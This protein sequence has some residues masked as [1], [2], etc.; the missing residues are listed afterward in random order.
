MKRIFAGRPL[1]GKLFP[2]LLGAGAL[3]GLYAGARGARPPEL[4]GALAALV[5]FL[6]AWNARRRAS[7]G[8]GVFF[9]LAGAALAFLAAELCFTR[10]AGAC[11]GAAG[12]G[13]LLQL[14]ATLLL[15]R[16]LALTGAAGPSR[17]PSGGGAPDSGSPLKTREEREAPARGGTADLERSKRLSDIGTLASTVAHELRNPLTAIRVAARNIKKKAPDPGLA[18]HLAS[19]DRKI[20]E[21]SQIIDNLLFYSRLRPPQHESVD[22]F[23]E[24][25]DCVEDLRESCGWGIAVT[26]DF[27]ALKGARLEADPVQLREV[28]N[29][30]L[31]N[32]RD[33]APPAGGKVL[34]EGLRRGGRVVV[35]VRDNGPGLDGE[36][37][38]K[39]FDP[40][41]TTKAKGTGL[42]LTVCREIAAFHG[43]SI[44]MRSAPGAGT[45]VVVSLPE[46]RTGP[47]AAPP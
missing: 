16:A 37:L 40:F 15:C 6:L 1:P 22:I 33:A 28:L 25:S 4:L 24:L 21:S 31:N 11:G 29:N 39:A 36:T 7:S 43:G 38:A 35:T 42:G 13:R 5:L 18:R 34:V 45:A 19:I 27:D 3:A 14:A 41:F 8:R 12:D 2:A 10:Y 46:R 26:G 47:A 9:S 32:A 30:V 44:K 17:P 20:A 23:R